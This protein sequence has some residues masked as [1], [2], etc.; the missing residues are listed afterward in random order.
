MALT[1]NKSQSA[2]KWA[3]LDLPKAPHT[4]FALSCSKEEKSWWNNGGQTRKH[5]QEKDRS[6]WGGPRKDTPIVGRRKSVRIGNTVR[7]PLLLLFFSSYK[8]GVDPPNLTLVLY[9]TIP[10]IFSILTDN[11]GPFSMPWKLLS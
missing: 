8:G 2:S 4:L 3:K 10:L 11:N 5:E 7:H 9:S 1:N 6:Q